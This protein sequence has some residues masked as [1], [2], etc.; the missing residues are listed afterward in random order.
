MIKNYSIIVPIH[1]SS[2]FITKL[3]DSI[4][5]RNDTEVILVDDHSRDFDKLK[6]VVGSHPQAGRVQLIQNELASSAGIARNEGLKLASGRWI[7]MADSDDYFTKE[8]SSALDKYADSNHDMVIFKPKAFKEGSGERSN[9]LEYI[10]YC[11]G[12]LDAGAVSTEDFAYRITSIWSKIYRAE[13]VK[14]VKFRG[15]KVANDAFWSAAATHSC[16]KGIRVDREAH[17][18]NV[19]ERQGSIT[20]TRRYNLQRV[21]QRVWERSRTDGWL[22]FALLRSDRRLPRL[23]RHRSLLR[24]LYLPK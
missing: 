12:E 19:N 10:D 8:F 1:N 9:R 6:S 20:R 23:A 24:K 22:A 14:T 15:T 3:L 13:K 21:A 7:I 16:R 2:S 5:V 11:F 18:Y 17:I 4:P